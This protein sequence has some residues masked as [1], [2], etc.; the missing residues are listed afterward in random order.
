MTVALAATHHDPMGLLHA[1]TERMLPRLRQLYAHIAVS[2]SPTSHAPT[3]DTLRAAGVSMDCAQDPPDA[4]RYLGRKR[5]EVVARAFDAAPAA[6]HVH[7][8]DFDRVLHWAEFH[9]A[10]LRETIAHLCQYDFTILGRTPCA[11]A[12]HPRVQRDT[13]AIINHAFALASGKAW[14]VTAASRGLSRRAAQTIN[15]DCADDTIGN[16]CSWPLVVLRRA[17]L[18]LAYRETDGLEFETPD[19]FA[20]EIAAAGGLSAWVARI[21]NDP[22]HWAQRLEL[23]RVEVESVTRYM[24]RNA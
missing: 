13:E 6:T 23:A 3:R 10:E 19:R 2:L 22:Q 14:D 15:V 8:C 20:A 4:F 5:R 24:N 18:T 12:S 11:F 9:G 1:Q 17:E 16:D 7:L 21:D